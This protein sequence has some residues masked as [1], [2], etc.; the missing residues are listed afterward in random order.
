[1]VPG[2]RRRQRASEETPSGLYGRDEALL[3]YA[4][5]REDPARRSLGSERIL[6][7]AELLGRSPGSVSLKIAGYRA[8]EGDDSPRTRRVSWVQRAVRGDF[9]SNTTGLLDTAT[10]VRRRML[11]GLASARVEWPSSNSRLTGQPDRI[12][13]VAESAGFP[14]EASLLYSHTRGQVQG[15]ALSSVQVLADPKAA[16]K[17]AERL[18]TEVGRHARVSSGFSRVRLGKTQAF[19]LG[20]LSWKFP[21]L[22]QTELGE[23]ALLRLG[24]EVARPLIH[25]FVISPGNAE[26][27]SRLEFAE[28][29]HRV[30]EVLGLDPS[31]LCPT[32]LELL[33]YLAG[34]VQRKGSIDYSATR[35][36][37]SRLAR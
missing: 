31:P 22:H 34:Q 33:G 8:L 28:F 6:E 12:R 29:R 21:T 13:A 9:V 7:L 23:D 10:R 14:P 18:V 2:G 15:A 4:A 17:F 30:R 5:M 3:I 20:I 26:T 25:G 24:R 27:V 19:A 16:A 37:S 1:M 11:P 35:W 32:C 36:S